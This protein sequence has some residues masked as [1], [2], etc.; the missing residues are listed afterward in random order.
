MKEIWRDIP[1]DNKYKVSN[2]GNV[3]S[4]KTNIIM[5][6]NTTKKGYKRVQLSN[7]K[8]YLVHRLVAETFIP[9]PESKPQV[10]H[11]DGNKQNNCVD[12]LEWCTQSENMRHALTNS[13]KVMPKGKNVYNAKEIVQI[14]INNNFI[15]KWETITEA[16]KALNIT[17]ISDVCNGKRKQC[18]GYIWKFKEEYYG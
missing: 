1:F 9:N 3:F 15:K 14:D 12:N 5:K 2:L 7:G 11:I 16:Q 8:R 17:H 13:L 6:Q 4:K 18:G 10:N